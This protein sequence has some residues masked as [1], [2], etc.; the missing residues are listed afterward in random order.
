MLTYIRVDIRVDVIP[1]RVQSIPICQGAH[2][3]MENTIW[4][5][6]TAPNET[7]KRLHH[8]QNNR[9]DQAISSTPT[10]DNLSLN[11]LLTNHSLSQAL[12]SARDDGRYKFPAMSIVLLDKPNHVFLRV[13][14]ST[15]LFLHPLSFLIKCYVGVPYSSTSFSFGKLAITWR[16]DLSTQLCNSELCNSSTP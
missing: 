1:D 8:Y 12:T 4:P 9:S 7:N 5:F 13:L 2:T 16:K 11:S 6:Q 10:S 14:Y 15:S 3:A